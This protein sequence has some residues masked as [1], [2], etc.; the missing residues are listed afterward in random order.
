MNAALF[1][2]TPVPLVVP[3]AAPLAPLTAWAEGDR[4]PS[5]APAAPVARANT[6]GAP[7]SA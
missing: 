3:Q 6:T 1:E 5:P 7:E 2:T 4:S